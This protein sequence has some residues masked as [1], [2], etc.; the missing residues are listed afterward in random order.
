MT[1]KKRKF[2]NKYRI[3]S[4][5]LKGFDYGSS[6]PYFVTINAKKHRMY[7][8]DI[9]LTENLDAQLYPTEIG[10]KAIEFWKEIPAHYPFVKLDVFVVMPNHMHGILRL[11]N[12]ER[13]GWNPNRF[14]PQSR[15]LG[16]IIRAFKASLKRYANLNN[17]DFHWQ[18][19]YHE[20]IIRNSRTLRNM[21]NYIID[22]PAKWIR[23]GGFYI[24]LS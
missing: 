6:G 15:N 13:S 24:D 8:G 12:T 5:R 2:K 22:N 17:I 11:E 21:Q 18:D 3:E 4:L 9:V 1:N 20:W 14:G 23:N 19:D 7:F 16:A 10:K